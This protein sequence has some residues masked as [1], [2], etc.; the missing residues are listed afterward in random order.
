[1]IESDRKK[2]K[3]NPNGLHCF[4][5]ERVFSEVPL[6]QLRKHAFFTLNNVVTVEEVNEKTRIS[7][8]VFQ[9][10]Y[11]SPSTA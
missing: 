7:P 9:D 11:I 8:K 1:M 3:L 10:I 4:L 6:E 5:P 2:Y